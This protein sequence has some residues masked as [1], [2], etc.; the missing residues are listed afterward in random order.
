[1]PRTSDE[2]LAYRGDESMKKAAIFILKCVSATAAFFAGA[3]IILISIILMGVDVSALGK[4]ILGKLLIIS[5]IY[6]GTSPIT[7]S[8]KH[9]IKLSMTSRLLIQTAVNYPILVIMGT[10]FGWISSADGFCKAT[11]V[12]FFAGLS[13]ALFICLYYP[14]K[15]KRYNDG[16]RAYKKKNLSVVENHKDV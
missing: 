8:V 2:S 6:A 12:Y 10:L 11:T 15:Y 4:Y 3:C 16:L 9:F 7:F 14:R 5:V 1:M 13:A